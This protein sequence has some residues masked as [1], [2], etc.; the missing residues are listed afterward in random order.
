MPALKKVISPVLTT[1]AKYQRQLLIIVVLLSCIAAGGWWAWKLQHPLGA[2][3][4][5]DYAPD[6]LWERPLYKWVEAIHEAVDDNDYRLD[7]ISKNYHRALPL[8]IHLAKIDDPVVNAYALERIALAGLLAGEA[9]PDLIELMDSGSIF[10]RLKT[11]YALG[12]IGPEASSS[13]EVLMIGLASKNYLLRAA[14]AEALGKIGPAANA[15]LPAL[16]KAI[17]DPIHDVRIAAIAAAGK[18]GRKDTATI[19]TLLDSMKFR[20]SRVAAIIALGHAEVAK[21]IVINRLAEIAG[22][23]YTAN[24]RRYAVMSL[25]TLGGAGIH[26]L[27]EKMDKGDSETTIII[28]NGF[29]ASLNVSEKVI[30][31]LFAKSSS[32]DKRVQKS[33]FKTLSQFA[34]PGDKRFKTVLQRALAS[35]ETSMRIAAIQSLSRLKELDKKTER[36]LVNLIAA[37]NELLMVKKHALKIL[38]QSKKLSKENVPILL[39]A[40]RYQALLP[41]VTN[42]IIG[43]VTKPQKLLVNTL[44]HKNRRVRIGAMQALSDIS[45]LSRQSRLALVAMLNDSDKVVRQN[46]YRTLKNVDLNDPIVLT[47]ILNL[48]HDKQRGLREQVSKLIVIASAS[49]DETLTEITV[50]ALIK[51]LDDASP[52]VRKNVAVAFVN[53]GT[54]ANQAARPLVVMLSDPVVDVRIATAKALY[55]IQTK[56]K[57]IIPNLMQALGDNNLKV[58]NTVFDILLINVPRKDRHAKKI[59][60]YLFTT[61]VEIKKKAAMILQRM[62]SNA[63]N[64]LPFILKALSNNKNNPTLRLEL[65]KSIRNFGTEALESKSTLLALLHDDDLSVRFYA[66][67]ILWRMHN[68]SD[69]NIVDA[70]KTVLIN[71]QKSSFQKKAA[72]LMSNLREQSEGA[73]LPLL[74]RSISAKDKMVRYEATAALNNIGNKITEKLSE[75]LDQQDTHD[76]AA[77]AVIQMV[78]ENPQLFPLLQRIIRKPDVNPEIL[79]AAVTVTGLLGEEA[80]PL[81]LD[82]IDLL[83][84]GTVN[85]TLKIKNASA[86]AMSGFMQALGRGDAPTDIYTEIVKTLGAIGPKADPAV[87]ALLEVSKDYHGRHLETTRISAVKSLGEIG[88]HADAVL[89]YLISLVTEPLSYERWFPDV[90]QLVH[91]RS[92]MLAKRKI[93]QADKLRFTA[94]ESL[95][96][97]RQQAQDAIPILI[98]TMNRSRSVCNWDSKCSIAAV[99]ALGTLRAME[100]EDELLNIIKRYTGTQEFVAAAV[101]ALGKLGSRKPI[102][103]NL[104]FSMNYSGQYYHHRDSD[105]DVILDVLTNMGTQY[106]PLLESV[107][108]DELA[109]ESGYLSISAIKLI[110][111]AGANVPTVI[112][113]LTKII[114]QD[115]K[116]ERKL[117][118]I[119]ALG[120]IG[121]SVIEAAP[122]LV[123]LLANDKTPHNIQFSCVEALSKIAPDNPEIITVM[124][125]VIANTDYQYNYSLRK[126][127]AENFKLDF[128]QLTTKTYRK[129]FRHE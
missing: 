74:S 6:I 24:E 90:R 11:A 66:A 16:L 39:S 48:L 122:L 101:E 97:Y 91:S 92:L 72:M 105:R 99:R 49:L 58:R 50:S 86:E 20:R 9:V 22:G 115:K 61:D 56:D 70:L 80:A 110:G 3:D 8:L 53:L 2:E 109:K 10:I 82:L 47:E 15:A 40:L 23:N 31:V 83:K 5:V 14:S 30:S 46:A 96:R 18:V 100:A 17:R 126:T 117:A 62:G 121:P 69:K 108:R 68:E 88:G 60:Q 7:D 42:T 123:K 119:N 114:E 26:A 78:N 128:W 21:T 116:D 43:T 75:L 71:H 19:N 28:I 127:V 55:K 129:I 76:V 38:A 52:K 29:N 1:L 125:K 124:E 103:F 35:N 65:I 102:G 89:P 45:P 25:L 64:T 84:S 32:T 106:D 79:K 81:T 51:Q 12:E 33:V 37:E 98:E 27:L 67:D 118:A 111:R 95:S 63:V 13:V 73:F 57:S 87:P 94:A 34:D 113:R 54:K 104:E 85:K 120:N 93:Y 44:T 36:I 112:E 77:I 41:D 59:A 4:F 107:V